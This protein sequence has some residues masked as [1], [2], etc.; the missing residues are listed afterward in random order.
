MTHRRILVRATNWLGDAIL[1]LPALHALRAAFPQAHITI[2]GQAWVRDLYAG[3][4]F[5]DAVIAYPAARGAKDLAAKWQTIKTLQSGNF[6]AAL[7]LQ[8]AFEAALVTRLAGIPVR[9]GY[10]RDGRGWLLSNPVAV[11]QPGEIHPHERFYYLELLRRAGWI[12]SY[13]ADSPIRLHGAE[14]AR[15]RGRQLLAQAGLS[16]FVIGISPGAAFGSAKRW[17]PDRFAATAAR[18]AG[19]HQATIAI[20]GGKEEA[21]VCQQV[22]DHLGGLK[23]FNFAGR[24]SLRDFLDLV[25]ACNLMLTN[26]SGAMHV[27]YAMGVPSVTV[28]GSTD[29]IGTGPTGPLA[30][31][32]REPVDCAPCKLRECPI[33][34]R[35]MQRVSAEKVAETALLL[36]K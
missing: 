3:E 13:D 23:I 14:Q 17:Y 29:E 9:A 36:L 7:L 22:A 4:S 19:E 12:A 18:V 5:C 31:I 24:T 2:L 34:H 32:V 20:F 21:A 33:D 35:C 26:D 1:S 11:P 28:F 15:N 8:N 25:A 27:A 30:R 6:D 10:N 16:G